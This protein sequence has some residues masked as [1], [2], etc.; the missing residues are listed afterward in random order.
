MSPRIHTD[1]VMPDTSQSPSVVPPR[2]A[3]LIAALRLVPHPEGGFYREVFRSPRSVMVEDPRG[4]RSACTTIYY[5][6]PE[7]SHSRW[8]RVES[9]EIWHFCEG[10]PLELLELRPTGQ[11]LIRQRLGALG[12][13]TSPVCTIAAGHWQAAR[14]LGSYALVGCTVAPG[15]EFDDFLLLADEPRVADAVR[16]SW[17]DV[18]SLI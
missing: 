10:T 15:F 11:A 4:R 16:A 17:P 12:E 8:H 14:P 18:A 3:D 7:G 6:L 5:L 9:D 1:R 2:A 13:G